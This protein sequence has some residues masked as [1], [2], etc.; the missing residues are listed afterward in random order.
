[1]GRLSTRLP[2]YGRARRRR[3]VS[4]S[5]DDI[6]LEA[7]DLASGE[8]IACDYPRLADHFAF[9]LPLAG[10]STAKAIKQPDRHQGDGSP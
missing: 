7:E 10:I 1:M 5:T 6:T 3:Q 4:P 8:T 2:R 9:F